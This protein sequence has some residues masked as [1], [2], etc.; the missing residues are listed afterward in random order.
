MTASSQVA[1]LTPGTRT[2]HISPKANH[3]QLHSPPNRRELVSVAKQNLFFLLN[4]SPGVTLDSRLAI[5][6][7]QI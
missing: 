1:P 6:I 3:N 4:S 2:H 5:A 7:I